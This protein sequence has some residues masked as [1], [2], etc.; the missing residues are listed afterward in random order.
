MRD[1]TKEATEYYYLMILRRLRLAAL[2]AKTLRSGEKG[3]AFFG[4]ERGLKITEELDTLCREMMW[5]AKGGYYDF[6]LDRELSLLND[7]AVISL[8]PLS[9]I[10]DIFNRHSPLDF[11]VPWSL[12]F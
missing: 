4:W 5:A 2:L 12:S 11:L 9:S 3:G 10:G 7:D 1:V 6:R 8:E